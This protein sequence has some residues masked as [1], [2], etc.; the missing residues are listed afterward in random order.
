MKSEVERLGAFIAMAYRDDRPAHPRWPASWDQP[1]H[2][3]I[4]AEAHRAY[5]QHY[6]EK[7]A[8]ESA[9]YVCGACECNRHKECVERVGVSCNCANRSEHAGEALS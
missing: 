6:A 4:K 7:R 5:V 9:A 2:A 8:A 1:E 3:D